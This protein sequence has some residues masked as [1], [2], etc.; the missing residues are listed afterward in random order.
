MSNTPQ[1]AYAAPAD[2]V[3]SNGNTGRYDTRIIAQLVMDSN[4]PAGDDFNVSLM[5]GALANN[6]AL[7]DTL[8]DASGIINSY[9]TRGQYYS[10]ANL[11]ALTDVDQQFLVRIT[12]SLAYGM[13]LMRRG[14]IPQKELPV[15]YLEAKQTLED[16][17]EGKQV[18][19]YLPA[20]EA[21]VM[22][23]ANAN[24]PTAVSIGQR[25]FAQYATPG[26]YPRRPYGNQCWPGC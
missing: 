1:N 20:Q 16:L 2:M 26:Y 15:E 8:Y 9:V 10:V 12:C 7:L 5:Q 4:I 21:G 14:S 24:L 6:T 3:G 25:T 17:A 19:N 11:Q 23:A 22:T 13:L 18:F